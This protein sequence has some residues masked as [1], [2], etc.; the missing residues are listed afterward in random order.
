MHF[1]FGQL[2]LTPSLSPRIGSLISGVEEAVSISMPYNVVTL[3]LHFT[4][5]HW[6]P[7][8]RLVLDRWQYSLQ[9]PVPLRARHLQGLWLHFSVFCDISITSPCGYICNPKSPLAFSNRTDD[10][11]S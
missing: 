1:A 7:V 5:G 3:A 9:K 6:H 8:K 10:S 11:P 2:S 4:C